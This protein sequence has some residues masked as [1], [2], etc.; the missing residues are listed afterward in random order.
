MAAS[1]TRPVCCS[2]SGSG[3]HLECPPAVLQCAA[4]QQQQRDLAPTNSKQQPEQGPGLL[5]SPG[6]LAITNRTYT[7]HLKWNL[8][9]FSISLLEWD[10]RVFAGNRN[11]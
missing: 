4:A 1:V 10:Y 2:C 8:V 6:Y 11:Y 3:H 5:P 9:E 7:S